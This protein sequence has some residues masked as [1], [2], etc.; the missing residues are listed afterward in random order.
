MIE[1]LTSWAKTQSD[2]RAAI[3]TSS[4]AVPHAATDAFS[5][6]DVILI[7]TE[8]SAFVPNDDW[9]QQLGDPLTIF[10]DKTRSMFGVEKCN[11]LVLFTGGEKI[12]FMLWPTSILKAVLDQEN[13]PEVLDVGY[14]V[15]LDKDGLARDLRQ[16]TFRA[17][18]PE[19]PTQAEFTDLVEEFWWEST[20]VAK[21]LWR[22][23]LLPAKYNL[24]YMMKHYMLRK[25]IEW[26]IEVEHNWSL[27]PGAY[28]KGLKKLLN[29]K[30]WSAL[31]STY[32]G[33]SLE[34]NW[35]ALFRTGDLF[36]VT[37]IAVAD[38]LGYP[39]PEELDSRVTQYLQ[40]VR[41]KPRETAEQSTPAAR[42]A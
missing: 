14:R 3:L 23:D 6:F 18:I 19:R 7:V 33:A 31:E 12:D 38:A 40:T 39:Y 30:T 37:A 25:M 24:D 15:L 9:L 10:R 20:Y 16:P 26:H 36:R 41:K 42:H 13:L 22:G 21:H 17:H 32:V 5:D 8:L 4:R 1:K 35:N 29:P 2:I 34:D 27:K 11:R 28:G